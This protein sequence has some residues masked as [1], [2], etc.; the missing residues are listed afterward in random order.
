MTSVDHPQPGLRSRLFVGL[1]SFL[2]VLTIGALAGGVFNFAFKGRIIKAAQ[3]DASIIGSAVARSLASQ[4]EK[5]ARF[6]VRLDLIP[7]IDD[8]LKKTMAAMPTVKSII[9]Y[10][11]NGKPLNSVGSQD[12][13]SIA[14][15]AEIRDN[16]R[17]VGSLKVFADSSILAKTFDIQWLDTAILVFLAALVSGLA[18]MIFAGGPL[19]IQRNQMI[20]ALN[21][22][23]R[24]DFGVPGP[25]NTE[26]LQSERKDPVTQAFRALENCR[27]EALRD[28]E[29]FETYAEDILAVDF[30]DTLRK[31]IETIRHETLALRETGIAGRD[32]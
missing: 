26:R 23:R 4:F 27:R 31:Q 1:G 30:E 19:V 32:V 14:A 24:G 18:A 6:D 17:K 29:A 25:G 20:G 11:V 2:L 15:S 5:A 13:A 12:G 10:D 16:S 8:H 22:L 3:K 7:G 28:R 21:N 9:L